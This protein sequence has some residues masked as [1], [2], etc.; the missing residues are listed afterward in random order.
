MSYWQDTEE[1]SIRRESK[2]FV[3]IAVVSGAVGIVCIVVSMLTVY[4]ALSA[5]DIFKA[6]CIAF[7]AIVMAFMSGSSYMVANYCHKMMKLL[8]KSEKNEVDKE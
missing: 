6:A 2:A 3:T 8:E 5:L 7:A 1:K 4:H